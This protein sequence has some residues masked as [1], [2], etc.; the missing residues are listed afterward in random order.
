MDA[1]NTRWQ[2]IGPAIGCTIAVLV[3][4]AALAA[5]VAAAVM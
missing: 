2:I 4:I 5:I 3:I 1:D